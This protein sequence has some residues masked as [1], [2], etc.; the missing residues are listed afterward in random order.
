MTEQTKQ[1]EGSFVILT[2]K[3]DLAWKESG[4]PWVGRT[5]KTLY[6]YLKRTD[7]IYPPCIKFLSIGDEIPSDAEVILTLGQKALDSLGY[8]Y[9]ITKYRG[10]VLKFE[11]ARVV[12]TFHPSEL[13]VNRFK[14]RGGNMNHYYSFYRDI[15]KATRFYTGKVKLP[16]ENFNL[17]PTF[18]EVQTW[19]KDAIKDQTLMGCDLETTSLN[20]KTGEIVMFGIAK[21]ESDA[22]CIPFFNGLL[23]YWGPHEEYEIKKLIQEFLLKC[24]QL[25]QNALFDIKFLFDQGYQINYDMLI[26]DTM[27]L[28]HAIS[29]DLPHDL[30]YITSIYGKAPYWKEDFLKSKLPILKRDII[31]TRRYNLRDCVVMHQCLPEMLKDL[32]EQKTGDVYHNEGIG[33][34]PAAMEQMATGIL[35]DPKKVVLFSKDVKKRLRA[36]EK[37]LYA[38]ANLPK[39][40]KITSADHLRW[41]FFQSQVKGFKTLDDDLL[42]YEPL[43]RVAVRCKE[44]NKKSWVRD[45][46]D[47]YL[48]KCGCEEL[49]STG[50]YKNTPAKNKYKR[51]SDTEYSQVYQ[52]LLDLKAVRDVKPLYLGNIFTRISVDTQKMKTNKQERARIM[53]KLVDRLST[54]E[55]FKNPSEKAN[56]EKKQ[57][58]KF[59]QWIKD[60][61]TF[62]VL[63]K[64]NSTYTTFPTGVDGRIHTSILLHG[65]ATGRPA[66]RGPNVLNFPKKEKGHRDCLVAAP[67]YAVVSFDY[68]NLEANCIAYVTQ[69]PLFIKAVEGG[70][71]HDVNTKNLFNLTEKDKLWKPGRRAS[72]IFQFGHINIGCANSVNCWNAK[73]K[74][75]L[76]SSQAC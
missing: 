52:K 31:E 46:N 38:D 48:C 17:N 9:G 27:L 37:K 35:V 7:N 54:I 69:D 4:N 68:S 25:W 18:E 22:L 56:E 64:Q 23:P 19:I 62:C 65:T 2:D 24:P 57:I 16:E 71:L 21:N 11:N 6:S 13:A 59:Q 41:L 75:M 70:N 45:V 34:I 1:P 3:K 58:L 51:G 29:P 10:S 33:C 66:S 43:K 39:A 53:V 60:Y 74:P 20:G 55:S 67:G 40:F 28:H 44:C 32:K 5:Y 63:Q 12:P 14:L 36:I 76:I 72:K 8:S 15:L 47:P 73:G 42:S 50:E 26:H 49:I 30:G 61:D